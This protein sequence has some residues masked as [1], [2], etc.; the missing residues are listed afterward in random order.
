MHNLFQL[1]C[2]HEFYYNTLQRR[3]LQGR[4]SQRHALLYEGEKNTYTIYFSLLYD[5]YEFNYMQRRTAVVSQNYTQLVANIM[6]S[7]KESLS[8]RFRQA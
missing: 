8:S 3:R 4:Q 5:E 7:N 6:A 1:F 2:S